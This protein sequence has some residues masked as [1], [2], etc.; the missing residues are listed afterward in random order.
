V[1]SSP[2]EFTFSSGGNER[3]SLILEKSQNSL[4]MSMLAFPKVTIS[5]R[6]SMAMMSAWSGMNV[7]RKD[8]M[9]IFYSRAEGVVGMKVQNHLCPQGSMAAKTN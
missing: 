1:S 5:Q 2:F 9:L 6:N 3:S 7:F 8:T 4:T